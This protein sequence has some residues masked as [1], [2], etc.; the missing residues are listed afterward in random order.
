MLFDDVDVVV[1]F[2]ESLIKESTYNS[3]SI[4]DIVVAQI[5]LLSEECH[6]LSIILNKHTTLFDGTLRVYPHYLVHL[7]V[8][9]YA[10]P[11]HL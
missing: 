9:P 7:Y 10:I 8:I 4:S 3:V 11:R 2:Y 6:S 1:D 5:H